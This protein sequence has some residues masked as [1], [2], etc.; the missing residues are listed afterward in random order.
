MSVRKSEIELIASAIHR[1]T[2][3]YDPDEELQ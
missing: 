2:M 1:A 3:P